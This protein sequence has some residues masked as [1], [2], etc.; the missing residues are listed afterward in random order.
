M[1]KARNIELNKLAE[2]SG[3]VEERVEKTYEHGN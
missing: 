3:L 1:L 2:V